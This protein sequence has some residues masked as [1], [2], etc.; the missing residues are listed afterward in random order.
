M[1]HNHSHSEIDSRIRFGLVLNSVF[2]VVEFVIGIMSGSLALIADATHNLTDTF[3]LSVSYLTN[4][5]A[6][7]DSNHQKTYGY[8]RATVL[9]A[10][11][12]SVVMIVVAIFIV[13]EAIK[14]FK[15]PVEVEGLLVTLVAS[16]GILVN[17]SIA[18]VL[19]KQKHDI[20]M[21]S[22]YIDMAFDALS[23]V[24]AVLTGIII[25]V[26]GI[27]GIDS[28]TALI[29]AAFLIYN[30]FKILNEVIHILLEGTPRGMEVESIT[31]EILKIENITE[32]DD[33]HV[34]TIRSGFNTLSCHITID[35]TKLLDSREIVMQVK[36]V[37]KEKF[38]ISHTTIEVELEKC[39]PDHSTH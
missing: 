23:S 20:N 30:T 6:K 12:N 34:W 25:A 32:V 7:R 18:Y 5:I 10:L 11:L 37:L 31:N 17:G 15:N 13:M 24:A 29:I 39:E 8:G 28:V 27:N 36:N 38:D 16:V 33:I 9:G 1:G 14:R 19:Y 35:D 2:T 4:K 22:A 3:T 21:K 26:T